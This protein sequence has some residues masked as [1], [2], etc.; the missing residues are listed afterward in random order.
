MLIKIKK[1]K[2]KL[3]FSDLLDKL[4]FVGIDQR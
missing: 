4:Q 1:E 2:D 3:Q